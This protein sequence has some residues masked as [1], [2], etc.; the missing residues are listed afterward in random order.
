MRM[1][2]RTDRT[3]FD[4]AVEGC[5]LCG[6]D[7]HSYPG[8]RCHPRSSD[9]RCHAARRDL[10]AASTGS[11]FQLWRDAFHLFQQWRVRELP[12]V[13]LVETAGVGEQSQELGSREVGDERGQTIVVAEPDLV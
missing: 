10:G 7:H 13:L 9:L 3:A 8:E 1:E 2:I 4:Q 12:R 11:A 5:L 6:R